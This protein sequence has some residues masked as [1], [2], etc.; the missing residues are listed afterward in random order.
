VRADFRPG[1]YIGNTRLCIQGVLQSLPRSGVHAAGGRSLPTL[2]WQGATPRAKTR[3]ISRRH[4]QAV[5]QMSPQVRASPARGRKPR[6]STAREARMRRWMARMSRPSCPIRVA[7]S[8]LPFCMAHCGTR[9]EDRLAYVAAKAL[10]ALA[11]LL[12]FFVGSRIRDAKKRA[13]GKGGAMHDGDT[14]LV[15]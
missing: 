3:E 4:L 9:M 11:S 13:H 7:P 10:D 15:Q 2:G 5:L 6:C 1:A 12:E 8:A 14:L